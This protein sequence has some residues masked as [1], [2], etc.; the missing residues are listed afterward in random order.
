MVVPTRSRPENIERVVEAWWAT[1]GFDAADLY[2][3]FDLDDMRVYD[4]DRML[5]SMAEVRHRAIGTWKPLVPKLNDVAVELAAEYPIVAF[6][7]D[8]HAP[9]S[10]RWAHML[11]ERHLTARK[12][13]IVYGRDGYFN[14][15]LPS[16]WSMDSRIIKALGRM[17]PAPVQHLFCDNA[18]MELGKRAGCLIYDERIELEHMHPLFGKGKMDAQYERVNRRQQ[19]DRDGSAFRAWM[20][21]GLGADA[22]LVQSTGG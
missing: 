11:V 18:V 22:T 13:S 10:Q 8:D 14:E 17:V 21:D 6:A 19:Y 15:R 9:R 7:G 4:Y 1:G 16:W 2:V 3:V 5:K 20:R 12:P